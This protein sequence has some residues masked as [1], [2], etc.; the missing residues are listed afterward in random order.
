MI[1]RSLL[2]VFLFTLVNLFLYLVFAFVSWDVNPENWLHGWRALL[3]YLGVSLGIAVTAFVL[4]K[5]NL[6]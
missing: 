6:L 3:A 5:D 2:G 4:A 1:K